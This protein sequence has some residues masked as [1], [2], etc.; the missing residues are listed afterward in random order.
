MLE[1]SRGFIMN[2]LKNCMLCPRNCGVNRYEKVGA[3]GATNK[4]RI[5]YYSLHMWEEP[6][7]SGEKGSGTIFF[8]HCNL[9]CIYCQNKK[10]SLDGYGKIV[11]HKKLKEIILKLQEMGAHNINLVTP[12]HYVPIIAKVLHRI[13]DKELK[14]PVVYNTSSYENLGTLMMMKN[15]VDIYLADL[16]YYDDS[17]AL[18]YSGCKNYFDTATMA[19][20]EMFRQVGSF[21]IDDDGM[22]KKGLIVRV[23]ILPGHTYDAKKIIEYLYHTYKDQILIS[24]MNQYTPVNPCIYENLNRHVTEEEYNEVIQ[25]ALELGVN[26][27]FIQEGEAASESFIPDFDMSIL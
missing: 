7:L 3:C 24:I 17:L 23:L 21:Q 22:M 27:A 18:N 20:D 10:I 12:T 26:N 25:Y 8:S 4:L 9:K 13:K 14:I 1:Y 19:I 15:L 2:I 11:S 16:K 5:A 6:V